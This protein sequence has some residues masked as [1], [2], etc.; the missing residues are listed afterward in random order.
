[1][2]DLGQVAIEAGLKAGASF[3]DIRIEHSKKTN[4]EVVNE[5]S[6]DTV[7]ATEKGAGIRAFV[8][9][10][11][12][13]GYT[14]DV[15]RSGIRKA[16]ESI[17]RMALVAS[18]SIEERFEIEAPSFRG[19]VK[20]KAKVPINKTQVEY[21]IELVKELSKDIHYF[22][23]RV[24][25]SR[26]LYR[27][28]YTELFVANSLGTS[29]WEESGKIIFIPFCTAK[30]E[31]SVQEANV[32]IGLTGGLGDIT[33]ER[34]RWLAEEPSK[35]ALSLL[36]SKA[37]KGGIYDV[38]AD[39][40]LNGAMIH[41]AFGHACEGDS[42]TGGSSVLQNRLG[43]VI[44]PKRINLIDDPT[45]VGHLGSFV[46]DW[47]GTL[48]T[49]R[50]LVE[51]GVLTEF[52][53]SLDTSSRLDMNANGAARAMS[54]MYPPIPRMS[55][56]YMEPGNWNL[57]ELIE[58]TKEGIIMCNVDYGYTD[59]SKGQFMFK[60]IYGQ[61]VENGERTHVVRDTSIAGQILEILHKIDAICDDFFYDAGS[62]GTQGQM[63]WVMSGGPHVRFRQVPVGGV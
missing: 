14:S 18:K 44:G 55:N 57:E 41:E 48:A 63:V 50:Q 9:G 22:D 32:A 56:T 29:V 30:D 61:M 43:T 19:K 36:K 49:R 47:E 45:S 2:E 17:T 24:K 7:L 52:M 34:M 11:W 40:T 38:I 3:V 51:N 54:F 53:H 10:S 39:P 60:S 20:Y 59:S 25:N 12:A 23:R 8:D 13:F 21:K 33:D 5:V 27:D 15:T 37:V 26:V 4:L 1:M 31:R 16:S 62:C 35:V 58:D 42:L 46:Y 28:I 6:R